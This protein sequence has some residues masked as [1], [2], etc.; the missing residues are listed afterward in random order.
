MKRL[1]TA[2]LESGESLEESITRA[3]RVMR[4]TY[5][6]GL[7]R[8]P[9]ELHHGRKQGTVLTN[10]VKDSESYLS[11]WSELSVPSP[12]RPKIPIYIG[13]DADGGI[14]IHLIIARTKTEE[15]QIDSD[16]G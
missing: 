12:S 15:K 16:R 7:N 13:R 1:I 2:N 11:D 5:R 8:A 10:I 4:F 3:L 6:T 14:S 9:F